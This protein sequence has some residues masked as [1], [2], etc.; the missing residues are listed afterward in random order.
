MAVKAEDLLAPAGELEPDLF[1]NEV[2]GTDRAPLLTRL[3]TYIA[4]AVAKGSP[5]D[6]ATKAWAYHRAYRAVY[7]SMSAN[8]IKA[9]E[10]GQGS[11][12]FDKTQA[13]RF[14]ALSNE[15]LAVWE[16]L[17]GEVPEEKPTGFP[18]TQ[19]QRANFSW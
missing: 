15:W 7:I 2:K 3:S 19:S 12:T 5:S 14:L 17:I 6:E 8:P 16:D 9:D 4:D 18:G 13:D 11:A 10:A 1:P